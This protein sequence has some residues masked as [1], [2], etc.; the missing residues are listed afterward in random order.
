MAGKLATAKNAADTASTTATSEYNTAN[1][2]W[3]GTNAITTTKK[4][5]LDTKQA[6]VDAA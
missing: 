2:T 4:G 6:A 5:N 1:G 3:T